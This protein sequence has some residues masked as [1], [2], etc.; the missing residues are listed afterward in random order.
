MEIRFLEETLS[1][2]KFNFAVIYDAAN[3]SVI[4]K[5]LKKW[6]FENIK[7]LSKFNK[8]TLLKTSYYRSDF[9]MKY[10]SYS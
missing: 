9:G 3:F 4:S 5:I 2:I 7:F 8:N 6:E 10:I 1:K